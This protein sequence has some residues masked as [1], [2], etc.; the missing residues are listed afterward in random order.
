MAD[1]WTVQ[2]RAQS[3]QSPYS[4]PKPGRTAAKSSRLKCSVSPR[5]VSSLVKKA[6]NM[7]SCSRQSRVLLTAMR[8]QLT[9]ALEERELTAAH[10]TASPSSYSAIISCNTCGGFMVQPVCMPCG[11]SVCKACTEKSTMTSG[12]NLVCLK[13]N[14][15]FPKIPKAVS[16]LDERGDEEGV[17]SSVSAA[18]SLE[19]KHKQ[20]E[21]HRITTLTLQNAF[22]KW[23][24]SWV[25]SCQYREEGNKFANQ[26]NF[27]SA[28]QWYTQALETGQWGQRA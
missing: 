27:V 28:I 9:R 22:R 25:E 20:Q 11:H 8:S 17:G 5:W 26:K 4:S 18:S 19:V 23:Y 21:H 24:P 13:C 1:A 12:D 10:T 3:Q 14:Q 16:S 6:L 7:S 2:Q 15:T